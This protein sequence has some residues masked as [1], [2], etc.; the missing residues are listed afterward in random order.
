MQKKAIMGT[1]A[2]TLGMFFAF[3]LAV[4]CSFNPLSYA[5]RNACEFLNCDVLFFVDDIF[6]L[7]GGPEAGGGDA[8]AAEEEGGG[9]H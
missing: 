2:V 7:S 5:G 1:T 8:P 9:G 4:G 3:A 6:P